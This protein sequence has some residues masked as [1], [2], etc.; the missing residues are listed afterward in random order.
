[1]SDG[2]HIRFLAEPLANLNV[3]TPIRTK[4][5]SPSAKLSLAQK[6]NLSSSLT[7]IQHPTSSSNRQSPSF[8]T[9]PAEIRF[10]IYDCL[11]QEAILVRDWRSQGLRAPPCSFDRLAIMRT[12]KKIHSEFKDRLLDKLSQFTLHIHINTENQIKPVVCEAGFG[13]IKVPYKYLAPMLRDGK[14][15]SVLIAV[16]PNDISRRIIHKCFPR[17]NPYEQNS[18]YEPFIVTKEKAKAIAAM[19][20]TTSIIQKLDVILSY[21]YHV[22]NLS[23]DDYFDNVMTILWC[24]RKIGAVKNLE[25]CFTLQE[26]YLDRYPYQRKNFDEVS[27]ALRPRA[28]KG[29]DDVPK[30]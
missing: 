30:S 17:P 11:V 4:K 24:F 20:K 6:G 9:L 15:K 13:L 26:G 12:N 21:H 2:S 10:E 8:E 19:L 29:M 3:S 23:Y 5:T 1:M 16:N 18:F 22:L 14:L 7:S 28:K 27:N 25:A